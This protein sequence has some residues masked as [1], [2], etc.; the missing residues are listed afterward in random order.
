MLPRKEEVETKIR[1]ERT[2]MSRDGS[3]YKRRRKC[4]THRE[5]NGEKE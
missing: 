3:H 4:D 5:R 1:K 2:K